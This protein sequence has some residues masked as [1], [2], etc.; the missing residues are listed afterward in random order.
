MSRQALGRGLKALIPQVEEAR[1]EEVKQIAMESIEPNPYQP[2]ITFD[3]DS[4]QELAASIE[5]K[6]V[7]QPITVREKGERFELVAGER[8]WRAAR[9]AGLKEIP[10]LVR[11]LSDRE[12][13]EI[14]LIENLQRQD[15]NPIEEAQAYGVLMQEFGL[16]QEEVAQAVGKGRP[17]VA[18][19]LRLL[20]LP[21]KVQ[22]HI[23]D[24]SL[25]PGHGKILVIM[26]ED[27]ANSL[28]KRCIEENWSVRQLEEF[29]SSAA[30]KGGRRKGKPRDKEVQ[31]PVIREV[32]ERLQGVL[33][34]R[35]R[36]RD[37]KGKGRI[38][39]EYYSVEELNRILDVIAGETWD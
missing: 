23:A 14:A 4:L 13:M 11:K 31:S 19:R 18:N 7:L 8:R 20:R 28:A 12:I 32:E 25:S 38:E 5:E 30:G 17:T 27:R 6:G 33:G 2:R 29:L 36:I 21:G 34:T 37:K 22:E 1:G 10:A 9:M 15:L 26:D 24:G 39:V 35:V 16:T 3:E